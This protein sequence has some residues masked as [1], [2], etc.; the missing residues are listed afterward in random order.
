[1]K[2]CFYRFFSLWTTAKPVLPSRARVPSRIN[3]DQGSSHWL[4]H[5]L[6]YTEVGNRLRNGLLYL[7]GGLG[8]S[9]EGGHVGTQF[10]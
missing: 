7:E 9:K 2:G 4:I 10:I 8:T 3:S 1:V 5:A 6:H